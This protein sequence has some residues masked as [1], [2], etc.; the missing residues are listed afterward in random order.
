MSFEEAASIPY[1]TL[2]ALPFL[3]DSGKIQNDQ[4]VLINGAPGSIGTYAIQL[5]RFFGTEVTGVCST[6]NLELV[7]SLG[8][9]KVIDYTKEDFSK[10]MRL[11]ILSLI[12]YAKIRFHLVED[13]S[14]KM[15]YI[16]HL[17]FSDNS[18]SNVMDFKNR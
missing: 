17:S 10:V 13:H 7:K 6:D 5:A 9:C 11:M 12:L 14:G 3:R 8:A 16:L 15:E 1:G 18:F 4:K 2:T